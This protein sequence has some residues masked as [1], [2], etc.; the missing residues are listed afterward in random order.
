MDQKS[1]VYKTSQKERR[2]LKTNID[3]L[4]LNKKDLERQLAEFVEDKNFLL[5]ETRALRDETLRLEKILATTLGD[6]DSAR[7]EARGSLSRANET[8]TVKKNLSD[9]INN[10]LASQNQLRA[11]FEQQSALLAE[12]Q[13]KLAK[14]ESL[15]EDLFMME[16]NLEETAR[17]FTTA[18]EARQTLQLRLEQARNDKKDL[19]LQLKSLYSAQENLTKIIE[20]QQKMFSIKNTKGLPQQTV[21]EKEVPAPPRKPKFEFKKPSRP[22]G[23]PKSL[24]PPRPIPS[25]PTLSKETEPARKDLP[26]F[27]TAKVIMTNTEHNYLVLS[28]QHVE[29]IKEGTNLVLIKDGQPVYHVEVR[30]IYAS[31]ISTVRITRRLSKTL[32]LSKGDICEAAE[33]KM[34]AS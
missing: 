29:N 2:R 1:A 6:L 20:S 9:Q 26:Y 27:N 16:R 4:L 10:L 19:A 25:G 8:E 7:D 13:N 34:S 28:L 3:E 18:Q 15:K 22:A 11:S 33:L 32:T 21:E 5:S 23:S 14:N 30:A 24:V 17:N 31:N 12:A